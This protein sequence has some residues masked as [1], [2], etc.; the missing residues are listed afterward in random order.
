VVNARDSESTGPHYGQWVERV[1]LLVAGI[2]QIAIM[3][4]AIVAFAKAQWL[5][6]F[7][8]SIVVVLSFAPAIIERQLRVLLPVE[9]SLFTCVFLYASFVLGEIHGFYDRFWWWDLALHGSSAFVVGLIGFLLI[10]VFYMTHRVRVAPLYV[11]LITFGFAVTVGT[12]WEILE[13][14]LDWGMGLNMQRSGLNDTMTDLMI[15]CLGALLAAIIGFL[16]VRNGDSYFG[17]RLI[18]LVFAPRSL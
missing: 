3:G 9:I 12:V 8:G 5:I 6:A 14:V 18:R 13:F 11:A 4:L 7:S 2:I 17:R 16:Y 15:N 1:E 10:Y